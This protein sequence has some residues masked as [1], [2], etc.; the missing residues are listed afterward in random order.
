MFPLVQASSEGVGRVLDGVGTAS[1]IIGL[2]QQHHVKVIQ[3]RVEASGAEASACTAGLSA[4]IKSVEERVLAS[5]Q[6]ALNAFFAQVPQNHL[7]NIVC[8]A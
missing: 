1:V 8:I 2:L 6:A 3:P 5:L 4:V 7:N